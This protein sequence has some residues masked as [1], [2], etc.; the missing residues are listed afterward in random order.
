ML[1]WVEAEEMVIQSEN[2]LALM[3]AGRFSPGSPERTGQKAVQAG[4]ALTLLPG[5]QDT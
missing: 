4:A 5:S 1:A 3:D 2:R